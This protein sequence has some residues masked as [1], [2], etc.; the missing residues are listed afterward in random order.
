MMQSLVLLIAGVQGALGSC[1]GQ[2]ESKATVLRSRDL[3][4]RRGT[5]RCLAPLCILLTPGPVKEIAGEGFHAVPVGIA[6]QGSGRMMYNIAVWGF[7]EL[8]QL[9]R[10][11]YSGI[12]RVYGCKSW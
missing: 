11:L 6:S 10:N 7:F 12:S 4:N 8:L 2:Q 3:P 5:E 1:G 9:L